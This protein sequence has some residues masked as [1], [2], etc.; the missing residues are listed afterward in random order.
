M[1]ASS[2]VAVAGITAVLLAGGALTACGDDSGGGGSAAS[3]NAITIT[4]SEYKFDVSG[5]A[6][7]GFTQVTFENDG[8]EPH[9]L[10]PFKLK[11]GKTAADALP[12]LASEEEPDPAEAAAVFDGDPDTAFYGTPGFLAPGDTET[13]VANFPAGNYVL[14]CFLPSPE[15]EVHASLGMAKDFTVGEG[16]TPAPE[17]DGSL[18]VT[19]DGLTVPDGFGSGTFEVT[20]TSPDGSD[21][22][23]VGPTDAQ[24]ADFDAIIQ[25]YFNA[26][27][28]GDVPDFK[29]PAPIVAGFSETMPPG[30]KGLIVVDLD[31]GRYLFA[32]NSDDSGKTLVSSEFEVS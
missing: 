19:P 30:A 18:E 6:T 8:K 1:T 7:G 27:G 28:T 21:F 23:I 16:N 31:K 2:R 3:D 10:I 4:A 9:I 14:V 29:F 5:E 22:N 17:S 13:T 25:G 20:N 12:I 32:G 11:P 15:G 24:M 26:I